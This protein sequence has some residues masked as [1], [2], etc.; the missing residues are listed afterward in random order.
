M[1][2]L[3]SARLLVSANGTFGTKRE[4]HHGMSSRRATSGASTSHISET[5]T[6]GRS[7]AASARSSSNAT[8]TGPGIG[9]ASVLREGAF[10]LGHEVGI[11][12][13][14]GAP[15]QLSAVV[16]EGNQESFH[17]VALPPSSWCAGQSRLRWHT[18]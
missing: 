3:L 13:P 10:I 17:D 1:T 4:A 6:T 7:S 5:I 14:E 2:D 16:R 15:R 12:R 8:S 9:S 18:K 11:Q